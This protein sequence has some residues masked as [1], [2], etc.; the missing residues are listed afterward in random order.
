LNDPFAWIAAAMAA[1]KIVNAFEQP[2]HSKI[3]PSRWDFVTLPEDRTTAIGNMHRNLLKIARVIP[4][5]CS[6]TDRQTHTDP[7]T[8]VLA[9]HNT[10]PPP[11]A[12]EVNISRIFCYPVS[13]N[14]CYGTL[15]PAG[16]SATV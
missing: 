3:D 4:E 14:Y 5:I 16:Q 2:K 9:H 1:A 15:Y 6:P 7:H 13:W 8:G 10:S 12:G 11:P